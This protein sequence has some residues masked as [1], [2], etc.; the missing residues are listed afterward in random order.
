[1]YYVYI[2]VGPDLIFL[3]DAG[4][5]AISSKARRIIRHPAKKIRSVP[6]LI[7][8]SRGLKI[9]FIF[10]I[11]DRIEKSNLIHPLKQLACIVK[12]HV[13]RTWRLSCCPFFLAGDKTCS[14]FSFPLLPQQSN[15][16]YNHN[17]RPFFRGIQGNHYMFVLI[18]QNI[19]VIVVYI[20]IIQNVIN[21]FSYLE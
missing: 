16:Q 20:S 9:Y 2:R 4:Y 15:D 17:F 10:F 7:F 11:L 13:S 1:M 21:F 5:S 8:F 12:Y 3:P 18:W 6:T 14:S 19:G